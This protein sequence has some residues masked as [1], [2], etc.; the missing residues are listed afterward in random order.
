MEHLEYIKQLEQKTQGL[1]VPDI[2]KF[3]SKQFGNRI[4]FASSLGEEDQVITDLIAEH[5]PSIE[6][7]TLDTG[8]LFQETYDLLAKNQK[9][10]NKV[11]FKVYYSDTKAVEEGEGD[12][13]Q[14]IEKRHSLSRPLSSFASRSF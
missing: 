3:V 13:V 5:A 2:L 6:V 7:F 1:S 14:R 9:K 8:R 4:S 12:P 11:H 10:Y